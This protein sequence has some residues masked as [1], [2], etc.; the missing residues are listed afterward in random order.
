VAWK[1]A[2]V[3]E[4]LKPPGQWAAPSGSSLLRPSN[5]SAAALAEGRLAAA[6]YHGPRC[7]AARNASSYAALQRTVGWHA[8]VGW[9][10]LVLCFHS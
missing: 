2:V 10:P 5:A 6:K 7:L 3:C 1:H 9:R 8:Q 4:D